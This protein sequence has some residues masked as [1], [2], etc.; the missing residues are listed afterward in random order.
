MNYSNAYEYTVDIAASLNMLGTGHKWEAQPPQGEEYTNQYAGRARLAT[1]DFSLIL[2]L[3]SSMDWKPESGTL[4]IVASQPKMPRDIGITHRPHPSIKCT[5]T[6]PALAV[7][8]DIRRRLLKD[9]IEWTNLV[10]S[11]IQ[12]ALHHKQARE[13]TKAMLLSI[14]KGH[15]VGHVRNRVYGEG[16]QVD[17][18]HHGDVQTLEFRGL[19]PEDAV[20]LIKLFLDQKK[21]M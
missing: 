20:D 7:A 13:K 6:R 16:W 19:H 10:K 5:P 12:Q 11:D 14:F 1:A 4:S 18:N 9:A 17:A 21:E 2:R 15:S 3:W 8:K